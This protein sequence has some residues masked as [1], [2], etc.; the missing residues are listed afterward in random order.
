MQI[1]SGTPLAAAIEDARILVDAGE[2][3]RAAESYGRAISDPMAFSALRSQLRLEHVGLLLRQTYPT[4]FEATIEQVHR[5]L[6]E[7]E[8]RQDRPG[9]LQLTVLLAEALVGVDAQAQFRAALLKLSADIPNETD[10]VALL[11]D[12]FPHYL[13]LLGLAANQEAKFSEARHYLS[14]SLDELARRKAHYACKILQEDLQRL[15]LQEGDSYVIADLAA[16][17]PN[18]ISTLSQAFLVVRALRRQGKYEQA[19]QILKAWQTTMRVERSQRFN[20]L[21]ESAL[22][23]YRLGQRHL[24]TTEVASLEMAAKE[25]FDPQE[26]QS[27]LKRLKLFEMGLL[28]ISGGKGFNAHLYDARILVLQNKLDEAEYI[29]KSIRP[30]STAQ[31]E[32]AYWLIAAAE[33][34]FVR[35]LDIHREDT[36]AAAGHG[37]ES[38]HR[39]EKALEIVTRLQIMELTGYILRLAGYCHAYL[40]RDHAVARNYW[41]KANAHENAITTQQLS[42]EARVR[43]RESVPTQHD[44]MIKI[45]ADQAESAAAETGSIPGEHIASV[46]VAIETARSL[47]LLHLVQQPGELQTVPIPLPENRLACWNW[48]TDLASELPNDIAIWLLHA[49]PDRIYHGLV[50]HSSLAWL[51]YPASKNE[52]GNRIAEL[53]QIWASEADLQA[54]TLHQPHLMT[55]SLAQL[56]AQLHIQH[57]IERLRDLPK[58]ISRLIIVAGEDLAEIPFAA[59]TIGTKE[60]EPLLITQFA[61]SY[62]PCAS[63]FRHLT[64]RAKASQGDHALIVQPPAKDLYLDVP[65]SNA[66][67][68]KA[69]RGLEATVGNLSQILHQTSFPIVRFDCH[70]VFDPSEPADSFLHLARSAG[71]DG[72]L[73]RNHLQPDKPQQPKISFHKCGTVIMGACDTAMFERVRREERLGL[74]RS[75]LAAGASAVVAARWKAEDITTRIILRQFQRYLRYLPRDIALQ[76]AQLEVICA[77]N[78]EIQQPHP[79]SGRVVANPAHPSRWA[80]F[81]L[82]GDV[83]LQTGAGWLRR[84]ARQWQATRNI[85]SRK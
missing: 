61:I 45:T 6:D 66:K 17:S 26:A 81:V 53:G 70:G 69:L 62:M 25:T 9:T 43:Y 12:V 48:Y 52:L 46:I 2:F 50:C 65:I 33:L 40:L 76:K 85:Y 72:R 13:R 73:T 28:S 42:D 63:A 10:A 82:H 22:L 3:G 58:K 24:T 57:V 27:A 30:R 79:K 11:S 1:S 55:Q 14:R 37:H 77:S 5:Y 8:T 75:A 20:L 15:A 74:I 4:H 68:T 49:T 80:C 38:F 44:E 83:G 34:F 54:S 39:L 7:P 31:P 19:L 78:P 67:R 16:T 32:A 56:S 29:L 60:G 84:K 71:D 35:G 47:T 23:A 64:R 21:F 41:A 18:T 51:D 36:R 59:L